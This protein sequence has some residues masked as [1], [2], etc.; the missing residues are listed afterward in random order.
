VLPVHGGTAALLVALHG[1]GSSAGGWKRHWMEALVGGDD[2]EWRRYW[3]K[4]VLDESATGWKRRHWILEKALGEGDAALLVVLLG[5]GDA[6]L[7]GA[8]H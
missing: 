7:L 6:V 1:G 8:L 4:A 2:T 5:G 3:V